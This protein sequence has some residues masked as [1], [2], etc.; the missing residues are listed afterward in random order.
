MLKQRQG[1]KPEEELNNI[2][3]AAVDPELRTFLERLL[4]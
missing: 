4:A 2:N 1:D 3:K